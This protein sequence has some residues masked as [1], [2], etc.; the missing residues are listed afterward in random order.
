M[1]AMIRS[2]ASA[3][4]DLDHSLILLVSGVCNV[5]SSCPILGP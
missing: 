3:A 2:L 4:F 1:L 5:N